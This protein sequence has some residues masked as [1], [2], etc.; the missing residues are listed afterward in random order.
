MLGRKRAKS[1]GGVV[2]VWEF[3]MNF[4]LASSE[5][6]GACLVRAVWHASKQGTL[7][8][9]VPAVGEMCLHG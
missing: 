3:S 8:R 4:F 7:R 5:P 9:L 2:D 6:G 1:N